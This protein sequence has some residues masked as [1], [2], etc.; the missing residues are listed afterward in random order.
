MALHCRLA[1]LDDLPRCQELTALWARGVHTPETYAELRHVWQSLLRD[2]R[3]S[4]YV[5]EDD[6]LPKPER[7]QG[8]VTAG[9]ATDEWAARVMREDSPYLARQLVQATLA[10][11]SLLLDRD[12][13]GVANT[14]DGVNA[15]GLDFALANSDW[16]RSSV[17]RWFPLMEKSLRD[18]VAGWKLRTLVREVY[19][20]DTYL[21][22]RTAGYS[23]LR[24]L[25]A[26]VSKRVPTRER[27]YLCGA[28]RE[29]ARRH[30][31][32]AAGRLFQYTEPNYEFTVGEQDV[33]LLALR[34]M[35]DQEIAD[36]L[37]I[38]SHTVKMRWRSI[39]THVNERH[40]QLFPAHPE[41]DEGS[42]KRGGE[43]RR[44]LLGYLKDHMEE[45]RPRVTKRRHGEARN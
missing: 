4:V 20:R 25:S 31:S 19:G 40:P 44:Y 13:L 14:E 1:R 41:A 15:F 38:S 21:M 11:E 22:A 16:Y 17:I 34:L 36:T 35:N 29:I 24:D 10:G 8:Y 18:W 26:A 12:A 45:L 7:I 39:F 2:A 5:F 37:F 33:L 9:F 43:K 30:P 6:A 28:T 42:G 32:S 27:P 3:L 23:L